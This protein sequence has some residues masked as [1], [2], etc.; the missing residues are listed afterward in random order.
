[1][2]Y[3]RRSFLKTVSR[4]GATTVALPYFIKPSALGLG[5]TVAPSNRISLGF[6]GIGDHGYGVNFLSFA[7]KCQNH[8]HISKICDADFKRVKEIQDIANKQIDGVQLEDKDCIHDFR[9]IIDDPTIDAVV[10]STP[11]HWHVPMSIMALKKGKHVFCEK[12]TRS[13][14]EGKML[15]DAV[16][17]SGKVYQTG[18]EDR[19]IPSYRQLIEL[20]QNG[21]IGDLETA[22]VSVPR[23]GL[24]NV[25]IKE[26]PIPEGLDWEIWLGPAK[27]APYQAQRCKYTF[28]WIR[29]YSV[30]MIADWG[31]HTFDTGCVAL[32]GPDKN[33]YASKIELLEEPKFAKGLFNTAYDFSIKY[34]FSNGKTVFLD[35]GE[36][37]T[38]IQGSKGWIECPA[39]PSRANASDPKILD[40]FLKTSDKKYRTE[41]MN[42]HRNFVDSIKSG[43]PVYMP[44]IAQDALCWNMHA[45]AIA[46]DLNESLEFKNGKFTNEKANSMTSATY[47]DAWKF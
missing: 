7:R 12:P 4:I 15:V 9:Q 10:I 11:D 27:Y 3:N 29:D 42:E 16:K 25:E 24:P 6:I 26:E 28:R 19:S 40:A 31:T 23:G 36:T 43:R 8:T 30:G 21:Y 1:M 2:S 17:A 35:T 18:L 14:D 5:N 20:C 34:T 47:R 41:P 13:L 22:Y 38:R 39:Y 33:E 32:L 37:Y 44:A 46:M 45:G